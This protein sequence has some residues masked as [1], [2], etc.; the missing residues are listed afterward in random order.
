[1]HVCRVASRRTYHI[2]NT[3]SYSY[4]ILTYLFVFLFFIFH[5][6]TDAPEISVERSTVHAGEGSNA[7]LVCVI[8]G[9][10]QPQV[11][12]TYLAYLPSTDILR[13]PVV[14]NVYYLTILCN[15]SNEHRYIIMCGRLPGIR[16]VFWPNPLI[17]VSS[18]LAVINT[19]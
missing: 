4:C 7:Q 11:R 9:E 5:A 15:T 13:V 19:L 14:R 6:N 12:K 16:I 2:P 10:P 1:M 18:K 17:D 3:S 8:F